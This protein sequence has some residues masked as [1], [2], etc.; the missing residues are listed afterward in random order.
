VSD[1][2]VAAVA[3]LEFATNHAP[4]RL[5]AAPTLLLQ[6]KTSQVFL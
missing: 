4:T 6:S 2:P 1:L 3:P 5:A